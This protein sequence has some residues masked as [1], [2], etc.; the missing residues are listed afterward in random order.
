MLDDRRLIK[1]ILESAQLLSTAMHEAGLPGPY[2]KTHTNHPC[3]VWVR[4]SGGNYHWL[5]Q[6]MNMQCAEYTR[7]F[8]RQHK[9]ESLLGVFAFY[10]PQVQP[11]T[12]FVNCTTNHKHVS[13]VFEAY[14]R[15][16]RLKW[17][18]DAHMAKWYRRKR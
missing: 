3:A 14:R 4:Q 10:A 11:M 13:N 6:L 17:Q 1:M 7:R 18:K 12:P 8:G 9:S 2:K 15:E 16:M 5:L